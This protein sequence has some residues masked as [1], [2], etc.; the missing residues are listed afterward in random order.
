M[1][2]SQVA[3][4][5]CAAFCFAVAGRGYAGTVLTVDPSAGPQA[6]QG[7]FRTVAEA[8][9]A[10]LRSKT[11]TGDIIE[12]RGGTH[13]FD[14]PVKLTAG[15][16]GWKGR[17]VFRAAEG[18]E[19]VISGGVEVTGWAL[20]DK[21]RGIWKAELAGPSPTRSLV[22]NGARAVRA[23]SVLGL[24]TPEVTE[25]GYK[26]KDRDMASWKNPDKVE[27]V[28]R[29]IWTNPRCRVASIAPEDDGARIEMVQPGWKFCRDKG[30]TSVKDPW[31]IENAYELLDAPGEWYL[32]ETGAVGGKAWTLY[33]K[34]QPWEDMAVAKV[35][36]PLLE[37]LFVFEGTPDKP[38]ADVTFDGIT[39]ADTAW[40]R[41][42][43]ER[44]HPDAQNNVIRENLKEGV[45][46][47]GEG[48]ALRFVNSRGIEIKD[49]RFRHL[50]G[51]GILMTGGARDSRIVGNSFIDIAANGIQVGDYRDWPKPE[52]PNNPSVADPGLQ[53]SGITIKNNYFRRCGVEYRSATAIGLTFPINC[54]ISHN[55]IWHMPYIGFHMG[56]SWIRINSSNTAGNTISNNHVENV[57]VELADGAGI[58]TLGASNSKDRPN[59]MNGNVIRRS[60]WG[61]G[62]YFDEG[63]S[64]V[65]ADGN[66][67]LDALDFNIKVNGPTSNTIK[68]KNLYATRER[69]T[70]TEGAKDI[71]IEPAIIVSDANRAALDKIK[72]SAGLEK[73]YRHLR[74]VVRDP[75]IL[76][77]EEAELALPA[78]TSSGL[79][80][81]IHGYEGMGFVEGFGSS[82]GGLI[83]C[84]FEMSKPEER[85]LAIRYSLAGEAKKAL[86]LSVNGGK[87]VD[88][89]PEPTGDRSK[90]ETWTT[91]AALRQGANTI[92]LRDAAGGVDGLV[93]DR[94]E[95]R[96]VA[97]K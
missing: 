32:D 68:V 27:M 91:K 76:E 47:V 69:N 10:A 13:R 60:R 86:A 77:V 22:V 97:K 79:G 54:E 78:Q 75:Y 51:V 56:W 20:Y 67:T 18:A 7:T 28:Y 2:F 4:F 21:E 80:N 71:Q 52:S 84:A 31:Y 70:V 42:S 9:Q 19:P 37:N 26:S 39:F 30:I 66:A 63:S 61:H 36:L 64:F 74:H 58:Y 96:P 44:G 40:L 87:P 29:A 55:E 95:L 72:A 6:P 43:S 8:V 46:F 1:K 33:Y 34:P 81:G 82:P 62:M 17:L 59:T 3:A 11:D 38:V 83:E 15:Q 48:A 85:T 12:L 41:P 24:N 88:F 5:C 49:C 25:T 50:G 14:K 57:M 45:E 93:V 73:E 53:I 89:K 16:L 35:V 65:I 92:A 94:I 90:W 23:R